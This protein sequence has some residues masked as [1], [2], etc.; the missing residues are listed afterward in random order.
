[1]DSKKIR[2]SK[3]IISKPKISEKSIFQ[4]FFKLILIKCPGTLD[5]IFHKICLQKSARFWEIHKKHPAQKNKKAWIFQ[6]LNYLFP[7]Q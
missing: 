1:L 2:P 6:G 4:K 3:E 5:F 7:L